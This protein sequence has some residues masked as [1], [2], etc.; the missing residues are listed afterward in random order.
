MVNTQGFAQASQNRVL[1]CVA[2]SLT[3]TRGTPKALH[4]VNKD[5]AVASAVQTSTGSNIHE[6]AKIIHDNQD[7]PKSTILGQTLRSLRAT[8]AHMQ[9]VK[10]HYF[11]RRDPVDRLTERTR[12]NVSRTRVGTVK[13]LPHKRTHL[14]SHT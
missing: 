13:A 11:I 3:H 1:K 7:L 6:V 5:A 4:H 14:S 12:N 10:T 8:L 2:V 9:V